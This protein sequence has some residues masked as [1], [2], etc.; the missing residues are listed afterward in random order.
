MGKGISD[1]GLE[2]IQSLPSTR[3]AELVSHG[4]ILDAQ[5]KALDERLALYK[6]RIRTEAERELNARSIE[7][8]GATYEFAGLEVGQVA[9][10]SFPEGR[11]VSDFT[12]DPTGE[13]VTVKDKKAVKLGNLRADCGVH[14]EALFWQ[15][16]KPAKG[17]K[18]MALRLLGNQRGAKVL[19]AITFGQGPRV[20]FKTAVAKAQ[21]E[22][23]ELEKAA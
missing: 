7:L 5:L 10:V 22:A 20:S 15:V 16:F 12:I 6:A 13:A 19:R 17:F 8:E 23:A 2:E 18:E 1:L 14:F 21:G 11:L 4:L 9:A 3:I